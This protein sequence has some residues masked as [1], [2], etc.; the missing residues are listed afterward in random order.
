[1]TERTACL[2]YTWKTDAR[3]SQETDLCGV[4]HGNGTSE[5]EDETA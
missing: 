4:E 2:A 3:P 1:M 5:A